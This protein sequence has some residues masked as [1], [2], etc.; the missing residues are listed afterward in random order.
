MNRALRGT[1]M[2]GLLRSTK[3]GIHHLGVGGLW[4]TV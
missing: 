2:P 1:R 3:Y 4:Q